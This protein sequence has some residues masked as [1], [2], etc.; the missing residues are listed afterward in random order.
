VANLSA[1]GSAVAL[2]CALALLAALPERGSAQFWSSRL[3]ATH[4]VDKTNEGSDPRDTAARQAAAY[5]ILRDFV[6]T[7]AGKHEPDAASMPAMVVPRMR[8]YR[9]AYAR[10]ISAAKLTTADVA[11]YVDDYTFRQ[12]VVTKYFAASDRE[13]YL[14]QQWAKRTRGSGLETTD[15]DQAVADEQLSAL[16]AKITP[17]AKQ[18]I[19]R[20]LPLL[21]LPL[22]LLFVI[23]VLSLLRDATATFGIRGMTTP[24]LV[25]GWTSYDIKEFTGT[26]EDASGHTAFLR[27]REGREHALPAT[28]LNRVAARPG[29]VLSA[30]WAQRTSSEKAKPIELLIQNHTTEQLA[31]DDERLSA[32]LKPKAW[33]YWTLLIGALAFVGWAAVGPIVYMLG[34]RTINAELLATSLVKTALASIVLVPLAGAI[35]RGFATRARV[36]RCKRAIGD[37]IL[38]NLTL[39]AAPLRE[40]SRS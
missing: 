17:D 16:Y 29:H 7:G 35:W 18:F 1:R 21:A 19:E 11:R 3:P 13:S 5:E 28:R 24:R 22:A 10:A 26:L 23:G 6:E 25:A 4:F 30:V 36:A 9:K 20:R 15:M 8:E 2:A 32:L 14:R 39:E 38:P 31:Y 34:T 40:R 12:D 27:D 33:F 37:R